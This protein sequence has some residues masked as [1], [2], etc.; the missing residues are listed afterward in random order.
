MRRRRT[1]E[2]PHDSAAGE[3]LAFEREC[4]AAGAAEQLGAVRSW[5]WMLAESGND[6]EIGALFLEF[7][8]SERAGMLP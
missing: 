5:R 8:R 7:A 3:L 1:A 2:P 6:P 4:A